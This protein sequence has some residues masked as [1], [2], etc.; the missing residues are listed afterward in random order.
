MKLETFVEF[1]D[2]GNGP[3]A[4]FRSD[5]AFMGQHRESEYIV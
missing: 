5:Y 4:E 2:F 3:V 1:K